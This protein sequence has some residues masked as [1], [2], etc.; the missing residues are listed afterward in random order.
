L[1]AEI[2]MKAPDC[3]N[4]FDE[5]DRLI[6]AFANP[7]Y[8][9]TPQEY[10]AEYNHVREQFRKIGVG[11]KESR[12]F[13]GRD[14]IDRPLEFER[15]HK[16]MLRWGKS[17]EEAS[18]NFLDVHL[19]QGECPNCVGLFQGLRRKIV[20]E[21]IEFEELDTS[22]PEVRRRLFEDYD[23]QVFGYPSNIPY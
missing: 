3:P 1:E 18:H 4:D 19:I 16:Y 9:Q 20:E 7:T 6:S 10:E 21:D 17:R 11:D 8:D 13:M 15:E 22:D 2:K 12:M 23:L 5:L 14:F